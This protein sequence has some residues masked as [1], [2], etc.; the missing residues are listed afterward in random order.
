MNRQSS[1]KRI[2]EVP[3]TRSALA[4]VSW[5]PGRQPL[6]DGMTP[7]GREYY[8]DQ[9]ERLSSGRWQCDAGSIE[10]E[11]SPNERLY[12]IIHGVLRITDA[13]GSNESF[14]AGECVAIP[15]GFTGLWSHSDKFAAYYISLRDVDGGDG[16]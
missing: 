7:R 13:A 5:L 6:S 8:R 15:K 16:S 14:G 2:G 10:I 9:T 3:A 12:F 11:D 1:F 4:P